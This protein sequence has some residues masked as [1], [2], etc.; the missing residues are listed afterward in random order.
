MSGRRPAR[1][2]DLTFDE[3]D[4][5]RKLNRGATT[6]M[7]DTQ[8]DHMIARGLAERRP[9]GPGLSPLGRDIMTRMVAERGKPA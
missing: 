1:W 7:I 2:A 5:L 9:S 3:Q 8:V 4:M 6:L